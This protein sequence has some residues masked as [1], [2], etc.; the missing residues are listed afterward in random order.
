VLLA[1]P[2]ENL[3]ART[4]G[5][6]GCGV[7]VEPEDR[8]GWLA[9]AT[10]MLDDPAASAAMGERGRAY[11][12]KNFAIDTVADRFEAVLTAALTAGARRSSI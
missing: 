3:A 11:A 8:A 9:A 5:A 10:A 6:E 2:R 1:A 4:V 12:E 7:V